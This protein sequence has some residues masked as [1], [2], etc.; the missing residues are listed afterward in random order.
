M[1]PIKLSW[2]DFKGFVD[3]RTVKYHEFTKD[4]F[5]HLYAV[6]GPVMVCC[7]L[8]KS[9]S[10][11]TE[12]DDYED[13]YQAYA[14]GTYSDS[15][16]RPIM[17]PAVSPEGWHYQFLSLEI[18]TA[19]LNSVYCKDKDGNNITTFTE[20]F[21]NN[22]GTELVAGTQ[23]ELTTSCAETR[24]TF[25]PAFDFMLIQGSIIQKS[26][27]TNDL[28]FWCVAVPDI[29]AGSGGSKVFV[30][31][32]NLSFYQEKTMF[33]TDGRAGKLLTYDATYH[34]NKMAFYLKHDVGLNHRINIIIEL[35]K[36]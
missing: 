5:Y 13:N 31:N 21:Y 4:G 36:A 18:E 19:K 30:Q 6:D 16:G 12:L 3:S 10:S 14:N 23:L 28:R 25:E 11:T 15:N 20:K 2:T 22:A 17:L 29:S 35:Y 24:L 27:P 7:V 26:T 33:K 34:T 32:M 1:E 9:P 8:D